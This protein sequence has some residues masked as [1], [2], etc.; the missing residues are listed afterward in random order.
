MRIIRNHTEP[1]VRGVLLHDAAQRHLRRRGHGVRFVEDD[2]LVLR[3]LGGGLLGLAEAED[4]LGGGEGADLLAD[5]V[6]AAVVGG[7]QLQDHL[8]HVLGAVD[9]AGESEDGGGLAR[10]WW[11]I[12]QQ[13]RQA[14]RFDEAVDSLQDLMVPGDVVQCVRTVLFYPKAWLA[15]CSTTGFKNIC[16]RA[17]YPHTQLADWLRFSFPWMHHWH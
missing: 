8:A 9:A 7:V 15:M 13:V 12:E 3:D 14:V 11:A 5:D 4:L 2:E 17:D 1:R 16:T 6:D 10:S